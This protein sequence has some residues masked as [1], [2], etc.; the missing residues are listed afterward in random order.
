MLTVLYEILDFKTNS[1]V[2]VKITYRGTKVECEEQHHNTLN[3]EAIIGYNIIGEVYETNQ[4]ERIARIKATQ[5][6]NKK[7]R[8]SLRQSHSRNYG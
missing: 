5:E 8:Q 4:D 6:N 3:Q 2:N 1:P 7:E